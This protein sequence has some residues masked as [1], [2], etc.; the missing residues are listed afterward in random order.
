M[1]RLSDFEELYDDEVK[2]EDRRGPLRRG[3]EAYDDTV[4]TEEHRGQSGRVTGRAAAGRV[5]RTR[6]SGG[7]KRG[8]SPLPALLVIILFSIALGALGYRL[9]S[10][11]RER[12]NSRINAVEITEEQERLD[13]IRQAFSDG[14]STLSILR[15]YYPED[16]VLY[17]DSKYS[18][19][20][21]DDSLR[22]HAFDPEK[23]RKNTD[24]TWGYVD[25]DMKVE[26]GIDVS[27]HQGEIDWEK[28]AGTNITFAMI[29]LMYRGYETGRLVEDKMFRSNIENAAANGIKTGVYIFTQAITKKEVDE[30]ISM[31]SGLLGA[32]DISYPV[33]VDVEDVAG[34]TD[35]MEQLTRDERTEIVR[36]YCER[37]R[38]AGYEPMIYFNIH[39]ALELIDLSALEEYDKW[40][41]VYDSDFYYPY[42]Y[43]MWQYKDTGRVEGITG[44]V[45]LDLYFPD[46]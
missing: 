1:D 18:F 42:D 8:G 25:G 19:Y 5:R 34:E 14:D 24:G 30:E 20:P 39:G 11:Y 9:Y 7:R 32:Y 17:Y 13:G 28:V 37:I 40:F 26:K 29:R 31:L 16:L 44:N 12:E 22:K 46:K 4:K 3:A 38:E 43:R 33:V 15:K 45:D 23:V 21:V 35:R 27:A 41:A 36:Y 6:S 10:G 2:A